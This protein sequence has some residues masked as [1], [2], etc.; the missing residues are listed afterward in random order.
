[1]TCKE[2]ARRLNGTGITS[3]MAHPGLSV[4]DHFGK[5]DSENKLP[6]KLIETYANSPIGQS[7]EE[8]SIPLEWACTAEE[9]EGMHCLCCFVYWSVCLPVCLCICLSVP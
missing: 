8:G 1:M 5:S 3:L 9:L 2:L 4:T 7:E 6:S